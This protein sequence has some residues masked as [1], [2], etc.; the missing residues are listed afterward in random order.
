MYS[1]GHYQITVQFACDQTKEWLKAHE[2]A[3]RVQVATPLR[4]HSQ[5]MPA[6]A[7]TLSTLAVITQPGLLAALT[8]TKRSTL[9]CGIGTPI[10]RTK[11]AVQFP[12]LKSVSSLPSERHSRSANKA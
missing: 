8:R 2:F 7:I 12:A 6:L 5:P 1:E 3:E 11:L 4:M 9:T 10:L